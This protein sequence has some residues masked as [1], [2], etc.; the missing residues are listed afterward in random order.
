MTNGR[1]PPFPIIIG[2]AGH[3]DILPGAEADLREAVRPYA[4]E[5]HVEDVT[6][7]WLLV[8]RLK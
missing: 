3:R 7:Y 8:F 1:S 4:S 5:A 6:Y 2:V